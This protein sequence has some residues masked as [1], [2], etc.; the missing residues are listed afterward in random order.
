MKYKKL[1][2]FLWNTIKQ[3]SGTMNL[4]GYNCL[5]PCFNG[6]QPNGYVEGQK[7]LAVVLILVLME[8]NQTCSDLCNA[9]K[10]RS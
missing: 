6:I 5:N 4:I 9:D 7:A 3:I 10:R 2:L 8:Y 1:P